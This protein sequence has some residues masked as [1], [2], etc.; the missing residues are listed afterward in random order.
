MKIENCC[1]GILRAIR[2]QQ[3]RFRRLALDCEHATRHHLTYIAMLNMNEDWTEDAHQPQSNQSIDAFNAVINKFSKKL[4]GHKG[5]GGDKHS[6]A[7]YDFKCTACGKL[8][9]TA[10]RCWFLIGFCDKCASIG[11]NANHDVRVCNV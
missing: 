2:K 3:V 9:H 4:S 6:K 10:D 11:H 8:G 7:K 1:N 5:G